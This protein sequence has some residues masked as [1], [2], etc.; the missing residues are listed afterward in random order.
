MTPSP[1]KI[2][3]PSIRLESILVWVVWGGVIAALFTP[4]VLNSDLFF[5]YAAA[6]GLWFMGAVQISLAAWIYLAFIDREFRPDLNL[7]AIGVLVFIALECLSAVIG[8]DTNR[9]FWSTYERMSGVVMYLHLAAFFF[10]LSAFMKSECDWA[11][12]FS[13]STA[14]ASVV[15]LLGIMHNLGGGS[16]IRAASELRFLPDGI[17][18]AGTSGSTLGNTSFMGSYL[19]M[20]AF[21]A[22]YLFM[23]K[24]G[25]AKLLSAASI[26][27]ISSGILLN[28]GGRAMKIS[29]ILGLI[30]MVLMMLVTGKRVRGSRNLGAAGLVA[31]I[32]IAA[33]FCVWLFIVRESI[34]GSLM[35]VRGVGERLSIWRI[36]V[37]GFLDRPLMGWGRENFDLVLFRH[38]DPDLLVGRG[39]VTQTLWFDRS[40]N[41]VLDHLVSGGVIGLV[42][43]HFLHLASIAC[44]WRSYFRDAR[45]DSRA[46][47]V[48]TAMFIAHFVQN[49]SVF[50]MVSSQMLLFA[51]FAFASRKAT[52]FG[53]FGGGRPEAAPRRLSKIA[54]PAALAVLLGLSLWHCVHVPAGIAKVVKEVT[55]SRLED[56]VIDR[57]RIAAESAAVGRHEI[58]VRLAGA[59]FERL[60]RFEDVDRDQSLFHEADY[61]IEKLEES[62]EESPMNFR[63]LYNLGELNSNAAFQMSSGDG[64]DG[65]DGIALDYAL[66]AEKAYR[67]AI[68]VSPKHVLAYLGLARSLIY[69]GFILDDM[70]LHSE[71]LEVVEQAVGI[72]PRLYAS[73]ELAVDIVC[74]IFGDPIRSMQKIDSA[75]EVNPRW[76][77]RLLKR[78]E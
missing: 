51:S 45:G 65:R 4:L 5:P 25:L 20:N 8:A 70:R 43:F 33:V 31:I 53:W 58:R 47:I 71:A 7:I 52:P 78:T 40:H 13:V 1:C 56:S 10:L 35:D 42:S 22:I 59:A 64:L 36:A 27:V 6:K 41:V 37:D 50:D 60:D 32:S 66:A 26:A 14:V 2:G 67:K 76:R 63:I 39:V 68:N 12:L 19:L 57:Y 44:L 75:A 77:R 28:P 72:E 3:E 15:S 23:G 54:V 73:H 9:S 46:C 11:R 30:L 24:R 69:Q 18:M 61:I 16:I 34:I 17:S 49:L 38:F 55:G 74:D 62:S 29:L 48:F 21:L